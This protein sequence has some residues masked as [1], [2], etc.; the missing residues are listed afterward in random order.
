MSNKIIRY[1][2]PKKYTKSIPVC[3]LHYT[4]ECL[5]KN[6]FPTIEGLAVNLGVVSSTV[7]AWEKEYIDF[8]E[9]VE[10]LRDRQKL[11][12]MENGLNGKYNVSFAMFL[13]K[14]MH[15]YNDKAPLYEATQN[16]FMNISPEVMADAL[17]LMRE[18]D[19]QS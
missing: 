2:R 4:S 17:K 14:S 8:S 3:V 13:L 19:S 7:Y 6:K 12:L 11:L 5:E 16:N 15:G 10:A 9:T 18:N 1:G